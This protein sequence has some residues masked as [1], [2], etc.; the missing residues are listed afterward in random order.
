MLP[1]PRVVCNLFS[2]VKHTCERLDTGYKRDKR[3][4]IHDPDALLRYSLNVE[5]EG[6]SSNPAA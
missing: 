6:T 1:K 3:Y 5:M 4:Y 2:D